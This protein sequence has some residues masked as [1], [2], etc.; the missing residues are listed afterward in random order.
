VRSQGVRLGRTRRGVYRPVEI[1]H[2][3]ESL[4][5]SFQPSAFSHQLSAISYQLVG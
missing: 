3:A 5:I 2:K 4:A 1:D